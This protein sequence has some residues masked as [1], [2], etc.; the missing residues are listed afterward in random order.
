[1]L[2]RKSFGCVNDNKALNAMW[3]RGKK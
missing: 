3:R 1:M 2:K